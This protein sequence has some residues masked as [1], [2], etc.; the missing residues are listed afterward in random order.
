MSDQFSD[1]QLRFV[2]K[3]AEPLF[4]G[5]D[6]MAITLDEVVG[7]FAMQFE[8]I[9]GTALKTLKR[10]LSVLQFALDFLF[11]FSDQPQADRKRIINRYLRNGGIDR[12]QDA[13]RLKSLIYGAYYGH[14]KP[15]GQHGNFDN[16]VHRQ[17]GFTLP[18]FRERI[19]PEELPIAFVPD[20][21]IKPE[22]VLELSQVPDEVDIVIVGSGSGGAIA[23]RNLAAPNRSI[24]VIEAGPF[25]QSCEITHE[26]RR[27]GAKLYKNG[28]L[29]MTRDGDIVIF[30]G[31]AVG[32]TPTVNN[33]IC[34]RMHGDLLTNDVSRN[35][36]DTWR[37]IGADI[38]YD[39]LHE[40]YCEVESYLG[41][42]EVEH[43]SG[44]GNGCHLLQGWAKFADR[45]SDPWIVGAKP[46]WFRK[47]FG[48]PRTDAACAYCGY[49]NTGCP[50]ARKVAMGQK[51]LPDACAAGARILPDSKVE[52]ILWAP[53][54]EGLKRRAAAV[55]VT[56][57][58]EGQSKEYRIK[59]R[60]GVVVAAGTI[61][62]SKLLK[63]SKIPK[64][65]KDISLLV[66]S[67]VVGLMPEGV[68]P[69]W[70]EDQMTTAIDCGDFWLESHFQPPLSMSMLLGGWFGDMDQRMKR[71]GR[72][73]SAGILIPIDRKGTL[74]D[75]TLRVKFSPDEVA[76]LRRAMTTLTRIHFANQA[77][78][79]WPSIRTGLPIGCDDDIDAFYKQ[80]IKEK[81]DVTLS[82]A[83]PHGGNP[84]NANPDKGVVDLN[85]KVHGTENVLVTDA[86]VAPACIGV[87][88]QLTVMALAHLATRPDRVTGALPL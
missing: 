60:D 18:R 42:G 75:E 73:R 46:G 61:A 35:P 28:S 88:I 74:E 82:S 17:I 45:K 30:Q 58:R 65:G 24:L 34:L 16:A 84:I 2:R 62:S 7:N 40:A 83:H 5:F 53:G 23:A 54:R 33:G 69:A 9:G 4:D 29:Q 76:T 36:F 12:A 67:A 14:W 48:P 56:V 77:E 80:H 51:V 66:A 8:L 49:C 50:Y 22:H 21:D 57:G 85:C 47:N 86:S 32:G 52:E 68:S 63:R 20:R 26:E 71:Y 43:R 41:I 27:M 3:F 10:N 81:D 31:R 15:G 55:R 59:V 78:E 13:A 19:P 72:M 6:D 11:D 44:R 39:R 64:T 1:K 37:A 87:N 70:D 38:G 79:V 25:V